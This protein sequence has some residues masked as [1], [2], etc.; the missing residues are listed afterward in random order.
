MAPLS[1]KRIKREIVAKVEKRE[2]RPKSPC[3]FSEGGGPVFF[4]FKSLPLWWRVFLLR[5]L[6][7]F[8]GFD[9][10]FFRE[11]GG[12]MLRFFLRFFPNDEIDGWHH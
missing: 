6:F 2:F 5:F 8:L 9:F 12:R 10:K 11:G 4:N 3:G 7:F 1:F